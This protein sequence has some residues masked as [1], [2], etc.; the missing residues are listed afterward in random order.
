MTPSEENAAL[1]RNLRGRIMGM[2]GT[3]NF[4]SDAALDFVADVAKAV[5]EEMRVPI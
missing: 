4:D 1:R 2:W 3:G 5:S